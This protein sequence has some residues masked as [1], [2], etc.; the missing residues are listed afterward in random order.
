VF[1]FSQQNKYFFYLKT[2]Q[3][4]III[5]ILLWQHASVLLETIF[6]SMFLSKRYN[7][8]VLRTVGSNITYRVYMK[9]NKSIKVNVKLQILLVRM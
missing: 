2:Q 9:L 7:Q 4:Y 6:R 1:Q 3:C 8:C 5:G